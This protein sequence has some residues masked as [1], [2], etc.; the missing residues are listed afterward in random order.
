[1][2]S[3]STS[4]IL[5]YW[6]P[7]ILW[8]AVIAIESFELSGNVTGGWL[9][10]VLG[11][12]HIHLSGT[13]FAELHHILRKTGHV[14]GYGI[15]CLL[16]FRAWFHTLLA[17]SRLGN[18][19]SRCAALALSVTLLT[20]I[21]DEWHQSFDPT[22]TSSPWDVGLDMCGAILFLCFALFVFRSWRQTPA[23]EL[24]TVSV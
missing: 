2:K 1:L 19:R 6:L 24:E 12:M 5:R 21:L 9:M 7:A 22:R 18:L 11:W 14:T 17:A 15:L 13:A 3:H 10:H 23:E 16:L 20:A 8:L 4:Q